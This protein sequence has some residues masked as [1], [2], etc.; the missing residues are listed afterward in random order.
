MKKLVV[1]FF[2]LAVCFGLVL[3]VSA[4]EIPKITDA[5]FVNDYADVIESKY[6]EQICAKGE[7]LYNAT[8]AQ[9]VVVTVESSN[10]VSAAN[11]AADIGNKWKLGDEDK[12]NGVV[13]LLIMDTRDIYIGT[14]EGIG[15]A[16]PASKCG[17]IIDEYG[18][19]YLSD[20]EYGK[21]LASIYNSVMNELFIYYG[22]DPDEDY[23]PV[24]DDIS[25]E[26]IACLIIFVV[27][28]IL[29]LSS[30]GRRRGFP[31]VI[32]PGGPGGRGGGFGGGG[33][34]GGGFSGGGGSFGGG[35]AGRKF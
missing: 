23:S 22:L 28:I 10:G 18:I 26:I 34:S 3:N 8:K 12:D 17:R 7:N 9:V 24:S 35:G 15:G 6:E 13:I 30:R 1:L 21:G 20:G 16:L 14:G 25:I 27:I 5:F 11:Y 4:S 32:F 19:E 31:F 2:A 33:F 29:S